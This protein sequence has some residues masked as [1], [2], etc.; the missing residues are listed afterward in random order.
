MKISTERLKQIIKEELAA[1][2]HREYEEMYAK[3]EASELRSLYNDFVDTIRDDVTWH[4][5]L[6][7]LD[8]QIRD[9]IESIE[10][11]LNDLAK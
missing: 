10:I 4:S 6:M 7:E 8:E 11:R 3:N 5:M 2:G 1:E 9:K